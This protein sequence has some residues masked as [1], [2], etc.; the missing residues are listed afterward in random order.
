MIPNNYMYV[1]TPQS[2][3]ANSVAPGKRITSSMSLVMVLR[4]GKP[5]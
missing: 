3:R 2:G 5:R 1:F 4:E